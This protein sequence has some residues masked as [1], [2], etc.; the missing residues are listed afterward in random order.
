[1]VE[2]SPTPPTAST[3]TR[4]RATCR[5][6]PPHRRL[7]P[8]GW[9]GAGVHTYYDD[10]GWLG[11][12]FFNAWQITGKGRYLRLRQRAWNFTADGWATSSGRR[13]VGHAAHE[14]LL[15]GDLL[16]RP[17]RRAALPG[18]RQ[19]VLPTPSADVPGV[20]GRTH[21]GPQGA[22]LRARPQ[23]ADPDGLRAV[24]DA[25]GRADPL[26]HHR[27]RERAPAR[28]GSAR[29][30]CA[31]SPPRSTTAP[32]T[33]RCT[34]SG[35][36]TQYGQD[37]DPRWYALA[38]YNAKRALDN[39]GDGTG[40]FFKDWDGDARGTGDTLQAET[41]TLSL[42]AWVAPPRRPQ[43]LVLV[44]RSVL[45]GYGSPSSAPSA[46]STDA[47]MQVKIGVSLSV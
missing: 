21:L 27:R 22:A 30:R 3:G 28:R 45:D 6:A 14:P 11:L 17:A 42:L 31:S 12:A 19:A 2:N 10:N 46:R 33:T 29:R 7:S 9:R 40:L 37:H 26:H 16:E 5:T 32:S 41:S 47:V 24:A 15:R 8:P 18:H 23:L 1:M 39:S 36:S 44:P 35:C 38:Y 25:G 4:W 13:L 43:F 20:V 34:C